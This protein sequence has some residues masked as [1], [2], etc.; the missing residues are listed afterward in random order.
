MQNIWKMR[1]L[2][3]NIIIA[4]YHA[5]CKPTAHYLGA[6]PLGTAALQFVQYSP[7]PNMNIPALVNYSS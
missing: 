2:I 3:S 7:A 6:G 1:T 4:E 5:V